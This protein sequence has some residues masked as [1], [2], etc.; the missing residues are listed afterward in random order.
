M[1]H[2]RSVQAR[3]D[4]SDTRVGL[5][6]AR[7]GAAAVGATI[8]PGGRRAGALRQARLAIRTTRTEP[9]HAVGAKAAAAL[10]DAHTSMGESS[11]RLQAQSTF[12]S[13]EVFDRNNNEPRRR[14][15]PRVPRRSSWSHDTC[16][17]QSRALWGGS[18]SRHRQSWGGAGL[19]RLLQTPSKHGRV[20]PAVG[21]PSQPR[22]NDHDHD[23]PP[24]VQREKR[25][26]R[27]CLKKNGNWGDQQ[28]RVALAA[29]EQGC[30][31]QTTALDYGIPRSSLRCHVMGLTVTRKRGRKP[32]LSPI[33][34]GKVVQY[35]MGMARY[36]HPINITE[37]KIKV[38]EA[39]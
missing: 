10:I 37:L 5:G 23:I 33:E 15:R 24:K 28:L 6:A 14:G 12:W 19:S 39:T 35:I 7:V 16:S 21:S 25:A 31:V 30:P 36:G 13:G 11:E 17:P 9:D 4:D 32:I 29:V 1:L 20:G 38:A 22:C 8:L 18:T 27:A 34:E 2:R 3:F 26:K